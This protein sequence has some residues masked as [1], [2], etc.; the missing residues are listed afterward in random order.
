[1]PATTEGS[2]RRQARSKETRSRSL[3]RRASDGGR[4]WR[5]FR[6]SHRANSFSAKA[7][8]VR[9]LGL[10]LARRQRTTV[11]PRQSSL[12]ASTAIMAC[13][14]TPRALRLPTCPSC[15]D[16]RTG[17]ELDPL[18]SWI[19]SDMKRAD[20]IDVAGYSFYQRV[21]RDGGKSTNRQNA[22]CA[23]QT[24]ATS[25]ANRRC[26][27][28]ASA[29]KRRRLDEAN[30]SKPTEGQIRYRLHLWRSFESGRQRELYKTLRRGRFMPTSS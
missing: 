3:R 9:E 12:S 4:T 20:A 21:D 2:S 8:S 6:V 14:S 24:P 17:V 26:A 28:K 10:A 13:S 1:M 15:A 27:C 22:M 19:D 5:P 23:A 7:R 25:G 30:V 18:V 11:R 29:Q 16:G